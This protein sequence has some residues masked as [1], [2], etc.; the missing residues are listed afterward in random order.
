MIISYLIDIVFT[1]PVFENQ[2]SDL[3]D[4][5][6][7]CF[8]PFGLEIDNIGHTVL[9]EYTVISSNPPIESKTFEELA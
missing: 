3:F 9:C 7:L 1:E 2:I 6:R 4:L 5:V 8:V